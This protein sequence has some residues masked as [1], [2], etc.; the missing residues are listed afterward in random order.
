[1]LYEVANPCFLFTNVLLK[2]NPFSLL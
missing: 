1:M 2:I